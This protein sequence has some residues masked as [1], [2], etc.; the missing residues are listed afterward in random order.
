MKKEM[1]KTETKLKK[2]VNKERKEMIKQMN[3]EK[4][5]FKK[6][7]EEIRKRT[8]EEFKNMKGL[9]ESELSARKKEMEVKKEFSVGPI[10]LNVG[11][12][13]FITNLETLRKDKESKLALLFSGDSDRVLKID[14]DTYFLDEDPDV[15]KYILEFLRNGRLEP[16]FRNIPQFTLR[17]K[18][19]FYKLTGFQKELDHYLGT[20]VKKNVSNR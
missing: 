9:T 17:A 19:Q 7:C 8:E 12:R 3:T 5:K 11:G 2:K 18:S 1:K 10:R 4:E 15:F 6:E 16:S 13:L 20:D 14:K